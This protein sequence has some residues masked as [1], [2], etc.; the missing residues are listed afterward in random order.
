MAVKYL[1]LSMGYRRR[2][3]FTFDGIEECGKK[4]EKLHNIIESLRNANGRDDASKLVKRA[5]REF[6]RAMD[7]SLNTGK[8]LKV[9][10]EFADEAGKI[11][12]GRESA[13]EILEAFR[14]FD[15]V[16]GLLKPF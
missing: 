2:L 4:L 10:E 9:M 8:A 6:E 13:E 11:S 16:L 1:L 3:N 7:D 5:R 15:S 12:P 14:I